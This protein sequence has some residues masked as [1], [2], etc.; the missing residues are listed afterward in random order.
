MYHLLGSAEENN[1]NYNSMAQTIEETMARRLELTFALFDSG[2]DMM[3][4]TL[5]RRHPSLNGEEI[6]QMIFEWLR[7]RPGAAH[8]DTSGR[9]IELPL[10]E[11]D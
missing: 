3:R 7:T 6:E 9:Q 8:G 10:E 1:Y 5:K 4:Q 2:V 11:R